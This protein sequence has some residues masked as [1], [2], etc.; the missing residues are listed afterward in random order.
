MQTNKQAYLAIQNGT[1]EKYPSTF[2]LTLEQP[3]T[4]QEMEQRLTK[5]AEFEQP[6]FMQSETESG[7]YFRF[8]YAGEEYRYY[9]ENVAIQEPLDF[10]YLFFIDQ[11]APKILDK[12][13]QAKQQIFVE[14][15]FGDDPL[16]SYQLQLKVLYLLAPDLLIGQD[17][18]AGNKVFSREWL[19]FQTETNVLPNVENLYVIHTVYDEKSNPPTGYW[20]HTHGL[21]R[22]GLPEAELVIPN[23]LPSY[24][25]V[26][27][28]IATYVNNCIENKRTPFYEPILAIQTPTHYDYLVAIP[29]EEGLT[30][31]EDL[32]LLRELNSL[33]DLPEEV[34][35]FHGDARFLGDYPD[36]DEYHNLP[37]VILFKAQEGGDRLQKVLSYQE[38]T[39]FM[40]MKTNKETAEMS[41]RAQKRFPYFRSAFE[42]FG[43]SSEPKGF[44]KKLTKKSPA[45]WGFL[46]KFG[47]RF[48]EEE[49]ELEHMWFDPIELTETHAKAKLINDPFYVKEMQAN[50][51]YEIPLDAITDWHVYRNGET[52]T[53]ETVYQVFR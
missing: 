49:G 40:V 17:L 21:N 26:T 46:I 35:D 53:S 39:D 11:V 47:I 31:V 10:R 6:E 43:P 41:E 23:A 15:I 50:G 13:Q 34:E 29:W 14:T 44:F 3:V 51:V 38:E 2:A 36:R 52:Y 42:K 18:S 19:S 9:I 33:E 16:L 22:I 8:N 7:L 27:E 20:F 48:G 5:L 24:Y 30:Y 37:S 28:L 32:P 1:G 25:G 45:E 12:A 4:Y